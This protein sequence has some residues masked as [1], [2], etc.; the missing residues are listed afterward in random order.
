MLHHVTW[1]INSVC[2]VFGTRPFRT[3]DRSTNVALLSLVSMGESWHN[4]HHAYPMSVRHGALAGQRDPSAALIRVFERFGW[5]TEVHWPD[6]V[7]LA[8]LQVS[9]RAGPLVTGWRR[10]FGALVVD[11]VRVRRLRVARFS[12]PVRR[13][14]AQSVLLLSSSGSRRAP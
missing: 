13:N 9:H 11:R 8:T 2:H 6:P 10:H 7:R 12:E 4:L 5:A 14:D 3:R 1:S